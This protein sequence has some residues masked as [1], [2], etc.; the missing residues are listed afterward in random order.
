MCLNYVLMVMRLNTGI[1]IYQSFVQFAFIGWCLNQV[2][3]IFI[4][5]QDNHQHL[6]LS[7]IYFFYK[8]FS[9]DKKNSY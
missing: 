1:L 7:H 9:F 8:V 2:F 3:S 6:I 5:I 4:K